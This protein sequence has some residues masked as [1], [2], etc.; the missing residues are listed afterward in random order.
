MLFF[1][2]KTPHKILLTLK[3]FFAQGC[4]HVSNDDDFFKNANN[5]PVELENKLYRK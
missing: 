4:M 2:Y 5:K 3:T 1:S